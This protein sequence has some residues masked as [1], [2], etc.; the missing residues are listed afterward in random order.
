M[1]VFSGRAYYYYQ[2]LLTVDSTFQST[3]PV[4][5]LS[6]VTPHG[7]TAVLPHRNVGT[8]RN[9]KRVPGYDGSGHRWHPLCRVQPLA[10]LSTHGESSSLIPRACDTA[11]V[12]R[13]HASSHRSSR[14]HL[15]VRALSAL[16]LRCPAGSPRPRHLRRTA[17]LGSSVTRTECAATGTNTCETL[18]RRR[19]RPPA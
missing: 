11:A 8:T 1:S 14:D 13:A 3:Y 7:H 2:L 4:V 15:H 19:G 10:S 18:L 5:W 16:S 6:A 9:T 17:V 12:P